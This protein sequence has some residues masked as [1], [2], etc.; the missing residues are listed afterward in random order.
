MRILS[1][2]FLL[3]LAACG[4]KDA[5]STPGTPQIVAKATFEALKAGD[6]G[7]LK[8]HL[9]TP[10]EAKKIMTVALDDSSERERWDH[11][12][13]QEHGRLGVDWATAK[14]GAMRVKVDPIKGSN[15]TVTMEIRSETGSATVQ[16]E[17][18]KIGSRYVFQDLRVPKGAPPP[19]EAAPAGEDDGCGGD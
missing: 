4:G 12:L 10:E 14:L 18:L 16:V 19:K 9:M 7:P 6:I 3:L 8:D 15:A 17:M 2:S 13:S 5:A 11:I 1:L